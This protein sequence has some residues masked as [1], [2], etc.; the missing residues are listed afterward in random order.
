MSIA[1]LEQITTA[2]AQFSSA[3]RLYALKLG[4]DDAYLVS[5]G[6]LVEA[7]SA[8]DM[9]QG[10]AA[11]D[12]IALSTNAHIELA[13]LLGKTVSL[14]MSL[15]DGSLTTFSGDIMQAAM[16]GGEGGL[17]RFRL[18]LTTWLWRLSQARNSR[19]WQDKT[20]VEIVESVFEGYQPLAQWRWSEEIDSF[21]AGVPACSYR[22]Q[23][24]V[25]DYDFVL[26]LLTE[27]GL[28]WRFEETEDGLCLVVFA[29][30][31]QLSAV[32]EN[33][34]S[35]AG[36][37]MRYHGLRAG[38]QQD[39]IRALQARRRVSATLTTLL[40]YD[41]KSKK[42]ISGSVP[43]TRQ[44][45]KLPQLENFDVPDQYAYAD[46]E[47]AQHYAELQMQAREARSHLWRGRSTV[48]TLAG[49]RIN[50][51]QR[52]L[53]S[54]EGAAV[55]AYPALY[56]IHSAKVKLSV[57]AGQAMQMSSGET[58]ALMSGADTQFVS[59]GQLRLQTLQAIG[60]LDGAVK[61]G[62]N[63]IGVQMIAALFLPDAVAT[64]H[65]VR[66]LCSGKKL[67]EA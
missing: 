52:P 31:S 49:R 38:E 50:I 34:S 67:F 40:S 61:A 8:D 12:I 7:F 15:V 58:I 36:G 54:A 1:L 16:L 48:R 29:D 56:L 26:R 22:C 65:G 43:A 51:T 10:T 3:T 28:V 57:T 6:L 46:G 32:P 45:A 19:V 37:G 4:D 30:S 44:F 18:R 25:S 5:G 41:G 11:R 27:E 55:P 39:T 60:V 24:R 14:D 21:L 53:A 62:E 47:L 35:E 13:P 63:N 64:A 2:L 20:V 9:L 42:A 33:A 66:P 59:G 23:Y 17:A